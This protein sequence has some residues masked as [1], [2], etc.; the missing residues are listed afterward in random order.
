MTVSVI[1]PFNLMGL[2]PGGTTGIAHSYYNG[3]S[4]PTIQNFNYSVADMDGLHHRALFDHVILYAQ[5]TADVPLTVVCESFEWRQ[6]LQ[7]MKVELISREYIGIVK[8]AA[9]MHNIKVI[10]Q[11]ASMAKNFMPDAKLE[12][13]GILAK[14][15]HPNRHKNDALRHVVR[16][17]V[18]RLGIRSPLTDSWRND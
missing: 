7:K 10:F 1:P 15:P 5:R 2:D 11:S 16:Y 6:N 12:L 18:A 9:Q 3:Q 14:P 8:L 17:Q 4:T 13:M